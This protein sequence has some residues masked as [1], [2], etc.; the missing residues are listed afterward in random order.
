MT[1]KYAPA[2]L[3]SEDVGHPIL[4]EPSLAILKYAIAANLVGAVIFSIVAH[5]VTPGQPARFVG[6]ALLALVAVIAWYLLSRRRMQASVNVLAIG[7]WMVITGACAF[8]GGVRAP[9][10]VGYPLMIMMFGWLISRRAAWAVT[11]LTVATIIGL[12]MAESWGFLPHAPPSPAVLNG[13]VLV[14]LSVLSAGV[15]AYLVGAY[16][17]RLKELGRVGLEL[18][19]RTLDLEASQTELQRAQAVAKVGSW[20][21]DIAADAMRLS[22]ETCRL[23]G[24]PEGTTGNRSSYLSRTHAQDRD[25]VDLAWRAAIQGGVFDQEHRIVVGKEICWIRQKAEFEFSADGV[26]RRAVGITKDITDRKSAE[27]AQLQSESRFRAIIEAAPVPTAVN[28]EQGCITY[29]NQAF[30]QTIG[31]KIGRA[32]V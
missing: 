18:G 17:D 2:S 27:L 4:W 11:A 6:S 12:V 32:H 31:Y 1:K 24:L 25:A 3:I 22:A 28:D 9:I 23:F 20:V 10:I 16:E 13:V 15:I 14:L 30:L 5:F 7:A 21:Y 19:Q 29:L 26:A 8:N